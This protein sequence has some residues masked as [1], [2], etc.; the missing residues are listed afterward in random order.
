MDTRR[1]TPEDRAAIGALLEASDLPSL[2][3]AIPLS[4]V[5][6]AREDGEICGAVAL[7]VRVRKGLLR[8]LAV[9]EP[10]RRRGLGRS[11]VRS[12]IAR[13]H[14][15]GLRELYLLTENPPQ[16][17]VE[18]GFREVDREQVAP[19]IRATA[20]FREQCPASARAMRL[21]LETRL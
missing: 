11:L 8:S 17:F 14:E 13:A 9:A 19:E 5:L 21:D 4:N 1:A 18:F 12:A 10:H 2:P 3:A 6:V 16:F 20:E 7:E 15:L